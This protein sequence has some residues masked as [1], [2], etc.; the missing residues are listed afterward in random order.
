MKKRKHI[1]V[2]L[3]AAGSLALCAFTLFVIFKDQFAIRSD[4][5]EETAE[6]IHLYDEQSGR[7]FYTINNTEIESLESQGWV[8]GGIAWYSPVSSDLPVYRLCDRD[9]G[10]HVWT[11]DEEEVSVL[12]AE[13]WRNEGIVFYAKDDGV[14]AVYRL[15]QDGDEP[16]Y[17]YTASL[18]EKSQLEE[19]GWSDEGI[20]WYSSCN[21][22]I[23][24]S[25]GI[26]IFDEE[27]NA[28]SGWQTILGNQMYFDEDTGLARTGTCKVT[29]DG[30]EGT[31]LFT[32]Q[33]LMVHGEVES[34]DGLEYYKESGLQAMSEW[35]EF[36]HK[37]C[38]YDENGKRVSGTVTIDG[39]EYTFDEETGAV[40]PDLEDLLEEVLEVIDKYRND[41]E[42]YAFAVRIPYQ[43]LSI[44]YNSKPQQCASVMKLFVMGAIYEN[45]G[46]YCDYGGKSTIDGWLYSMITISDN[47]AW[48]NLV[49]VMGKG[50]YDLGMEVLDAW[51]EDHGYTDSYMNNEYLGNRTSAADASQILVD[52]EEGNLK[53]SEEMKELILQ[54]SVPGRLLQNLPEG[55]ITGNKPGWLYNTENDTVIVYAPFGT[56]VVTLLCDDLEDMSVARTCMGEVA[57]LVYNWMSE[58]LA[59]ITNS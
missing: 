25:N 28:L 52:I 35:I 6:C 22:K 17:C 36:E 54:Q 47:D 11:S 59:P 44:V 14:F 43:D 58:N 16:V 55:T 51:N 50:D 10:I 38:W 37:T 2:P 7:H 32:D 34:E 42:Q 27:G 13:N 9:T 18:L 30:Q 3:L 31:V 23:R 15:A 19:S 5:L 8:N 57:P 53:H 21:R 29:K 20:A 49:Y 4:T 46:E 24:Q 56:Y 39:K 48:K 41:G 40:L 1:A 26:S 33:G 45:Y 12:E